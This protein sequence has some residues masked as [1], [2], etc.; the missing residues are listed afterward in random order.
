MSWV[1]IRP[2]K[3]NGKHLNCRNG[4]KVRV[5]NNNDG[6]IFDSVKDCAKYYGVKHYSNIFQS[7]RLDIVRLE[8]Y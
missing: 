8:R 4:K 2:R 7:K 6:L 3:N 5:I 1:L